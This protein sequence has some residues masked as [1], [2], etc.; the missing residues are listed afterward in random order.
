MAGANKVFLSRSIDLLQS[1]NPI[2]SRGDSS[3]PTPLTATLSE[4]DFCDFVFSFPAYIDDGTD[5]LPPSQSSSRQGALCNVNYTLKVDIIRQGRSNKNERC[6]FPR[7][8]GLGLVFTTIRIKLEVLYLPR[9]TPPGEIK[10]GPI[11]HPFFD[12]RTEDKLTVDLKKSSSARTALEKLQM[13][14]KVFV[15]VPLSGW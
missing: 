11:E 8:D 7:R 9:S 14:A 12:Y 10:L 3:K 1:L 15:A 6:A 2:F 5:R 13:S 4:K